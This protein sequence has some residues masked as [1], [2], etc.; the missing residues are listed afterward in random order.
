MKPN[1]LAL[2]LL[3]TGTALTFTCTNPTTGSYTPN[4]DD[5]GDCLPLPAFGNHDS[6]EAK[7]QV[8]R[9]VLVTW[10]SSSDT[11]GVAYYQV[12]RSVS[13]PRDTCDRLNPD[14][15]AANFLSV[16]NRARVNAGDTSFTDIIDLM[17]AVYWYGVKAVLTDSSETWLGYDS[18]VIRNAYEYNP[19]VQTSS[20]EMRNVL[21]PHGLWAPAGF[22][23]DSAGLPSTSSLDFDS[24]AYSWLMVGS[25][26]RTD[27][28]YATSDDRDTLFVIDLL[29]PDTIAYR[30]EFSADASLTLSRL[31][32]DSAVADTTITVVLDSLQPLYKGATYPRP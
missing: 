29:S 14:T 18:A 32:P 12:Y 22:P 8:H 20:L 21:L 26:G 16:R 24:S 17:D 5:P 25:G 30:M 6:V 13:A 28:R 27:V 1:R 9:S 15:S 11:L 10:P 4:D 2:L 19:Y 3:L 31:T 7:S 23:F